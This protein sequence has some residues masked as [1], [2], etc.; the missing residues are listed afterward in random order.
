METNPNFT[1]DR[2]RHFNIFEH[3]AINDNKIYQNTEKPTASRKR[4]LLNRLYLITP[5]F[6]FHSQTL[7]FQDHFTLL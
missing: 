1:S 2:G 7:S 6:G 3:K 4:A 5:T